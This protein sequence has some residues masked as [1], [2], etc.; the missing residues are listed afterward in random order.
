[1]SFILLVA[2]IAGLALYLY[3]VNR[4]M[5]EVPEEARLLSPR[6]WT[7]EEIKE[8]YR[9]AIE[10]PV[11]VSKSL[12]PKQHRR[13]IVVGGSGLSTLPLLQANC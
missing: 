11:D 8:A 6:R 13:Y 5:T 10:S 9:K 4:G 2:S 12:P 7:V 3:H 1:M